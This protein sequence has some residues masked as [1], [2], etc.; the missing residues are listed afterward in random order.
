[1]IN[2]LP[3]LPSFIGIPPSTSNS[4]SKKRLYMNP[5]FVAELKIRMKPYPLCILCGCRGEPLYSA[6]KDR[7]FGSVGSWDLSQCSNQKCGLI[8]MNPMPL[9]EDIGK[10]YSNYYTQTEQVVVDQSG[11]LRR[12]FQLMKRG[13]LADKYGYPIDH[14][15]PVLI[16]SLG[17]FLYLFPLH[18]SGVDEDV[19][20]LLSLPQGRLLDVGCGSGEWLLSMR[21]L[22]WQVEG[23]D[24][25]ENAVKVA[26]LR[27][28]TIHIG[29]LEAQNFPDGCFDA[30]T[31]N[32]VI[33]HLPDPVAA[34]KECRR[35]LKG[36][37]QLILYTPN[38][39]SLG[40]RVFKEH[41]RGLEPPR[42]LH[43]FDPASM[44]ALLTL[45]GFTGF[46]IQTKNSGYLWKQSF[47]LFKGKIELSPCIRLMAKIV[48]YLLTQLEQLVLL[49]KSGV[50]EC[51]AV[52]AVKTVEADKT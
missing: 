16:E 2:K 50:G 12:I 33:E 29:S 43:L 42:H 15:W 3:S 51:L 7:L 22:G 39:A 31:L 26:S 36:N 24:F 9:T 14:H 10:A 19:R 48:P 18:R 20:C 45:A 23:V 13:Y 34:L 40:H 47:S 37:G 6:Q 52:H 35:I 4:I 1:M 8:W 5:N 27:G 41:W 44:S 11:I 30:V 25:D 38:N 46:S 32:H 28:L 17:K 21:K 49:G